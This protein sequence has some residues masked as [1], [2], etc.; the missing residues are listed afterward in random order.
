[1]TQKIKDQIDTIKKFETILKSD[2]K[3]KNQIRCFPFF[4]L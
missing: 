4:Y 3:Y 1:M 2:V